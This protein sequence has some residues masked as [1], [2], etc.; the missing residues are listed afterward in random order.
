MDKSIIMKSYNRLITISLIFLFL[1]V[2]YPLRETSAIPETNQ[3]LIPFIG[4]VVDY[5]LNV[6]I[7]GITFLP[8]PVTANWTV[9]WEQYNRSTPSIFISNLTVKSSHILSFSILEQESGIIV[10]NITSRQVLY[11]DLANTTF[12]Q[13]LYDVYYSPTKPNYSPFYINTT[14]INI[15]DH[16][17]IYSFIMTVVTTDRILVPDFGYRDVWVIQV[18]VT[19]L[20]YVE[21]FISLV[22]DD[23]SGVL[24]GGSI[25]TR[26]FSD[27]RIYRV[28]II[29]QYT[30]ALERHLIVID[31]N[32]ILVI[33]VSCVPI[34]P[35]LV[36]ISRMKE[37]KGGL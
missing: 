37:I 26:W 19:D 28:K 21:H 32:R 27:N 10:E 23:I 7:E 8:I 31:T 14:G 22:Y 15:D 16:I 1:S 25:Y 17:N 34:I 33:L 30:N 13:L 29:C 35:S 2:F 12:L 24:V 4:M 11:V 5:K 6:I 20:S 3:R 18:N 36:K 9:T